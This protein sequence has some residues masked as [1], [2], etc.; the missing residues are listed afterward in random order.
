MP[1]VDC[2]AENHS[3]RFQFH[4]RRFG[5]VSEESGLDRVAAVSDVF[6][7]EAPNWCNK[8]IHDCR[9]FFIHRIFDNGVD[10]D[11]YTD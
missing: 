1:D 10:A 3:F 6:I 7:G 9:I 2:A 5:P 11:I 4:S 8:K